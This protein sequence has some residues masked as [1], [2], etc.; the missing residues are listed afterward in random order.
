MGAQFA[1]RMNIPALSFSGALEL[2]LP[3]LWSSIPFKMVDGPI[4]Y[5]LKPTAA[6]SSIRA[7]VTLTP[8]V[9]TSKPAYPS[10]G[11]LAPGPPVPLKTKSVKIA[12]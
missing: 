5:A 8:L 4:M 7:L 2:T 6:L 3:L 1:L 10:P 12:L 9:F 11:V